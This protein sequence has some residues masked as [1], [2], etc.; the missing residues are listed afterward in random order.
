MNDDDII[1]AIIA[2]A[3]EFFPNGSVNVHWDNS[4]D[5]WVLL[6]DNG[7]LT[8]RWTATTLDGLLTKAESLPDYEDEQGE[9]EMKCLRAHET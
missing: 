8:S 4:E 3:R 5:R 7:G 1:N 9:W 2:N 6:M